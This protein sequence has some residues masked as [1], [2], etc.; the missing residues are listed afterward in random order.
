MQSKSCIKISLVYH[1]NQTK[2][3]KTDEQLSPETAIKIREIRPN[4]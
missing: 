2:K 1:T 4:M 3:V